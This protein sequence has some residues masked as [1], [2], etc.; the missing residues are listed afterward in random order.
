MGP[1][2]AQGPRG[3]QGL[4]GQNG[5]DG[6]SA[7]E[8]AQ[9]GGFTGTEQEFYTALASVAEAIL[10]TTIRTNE[11]V[12]LAQYQIMR[13]LGQIDPNT[14]YDIVEGSS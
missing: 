11:V 4:P 3:P 2:G 7:F 12:T 14:A 5:A 10:S 13:E 6:K 1:T 8:S 9:E